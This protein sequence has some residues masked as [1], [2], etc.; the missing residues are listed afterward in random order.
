V[1]DDLAGAMSAQLVGV[2]GNTYTFTRPGHDTF[3]L[4]AVI[5]RDVEMVDD[6]EQVVSRADTVRIAVVDIL[7]FGVEPERGDELA[8][9]DTK[10]IVGKRISYDGYAYVHEVTP[11]SL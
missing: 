7:P 2:F 11:C 1:F 8:D 10:Y 3:S 9:S 5:R 6:F 4:P